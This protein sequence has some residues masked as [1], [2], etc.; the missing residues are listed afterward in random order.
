MRIWPGTRIWPERGVVDQPCLWYRSCRDRS[1]W[2]KS[3]SL[4]LQNSLVRVNVLIRVV[5]R[6][7]RVK[8]CLD[9]RLV[10]LPPRTFAACT[11][12]R[13]HAQTA[14]QLGWSTGGCGLMRDA[15]PFFVVALFG[16]PSTLRWRLDEGTG[17]CFFAGCGIC[18]KS[19]TFMGWVRARGA[20]AR[21]GSG[22]G[23]ALGV[24]GS[25]GVVL[26]T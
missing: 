2:G 10:R 17:S 13:A 19:E 21:K 22:G 12:C 7:V 18:H 24:L 14:R 23:S 1:S 16:P 6:V 8:R 25:G 4:G 15:V 3:S 5:V 20:R 9:V 11:I 26:R